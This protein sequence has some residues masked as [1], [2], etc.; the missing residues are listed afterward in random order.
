[1]TEQI[2]TPQDNNE[3]V[4]VVK[5]ILSEAEMPLDAVRRCRIEII[6]PQNWEVALYVPYVKGHSVRAIKEFVEIGLFQVIQVESECCD[7][8][9]RNVDKNY[10]VWYFRHPKVPQSTY[11]RLEAEIEMELGNEVALEFPKPSGTKSKSE[12]IFMTLKEEFYAAIENGDKDIEYRNFNQYYCDKF[13]SPGVK[14][15]YIRFNRGYKSG[16]E[17]QMVFAIDY[18]MLLDNQ[19]HSYPAIANGKLITSLNQLPPGFVPTMY[20]IRLRGRV[21]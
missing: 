3:I 18:I 7:Y 8:L 21:S 5:G 4:C 17:N 16:K 12:Y 15:K 13:F 10:L 20:G 2:I 11:A 6:H 14:K 9:G 1:M 19:G